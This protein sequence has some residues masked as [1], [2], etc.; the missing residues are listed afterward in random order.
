MAATTLNNVVTKIK[1]RFDYSIQ[2]PTGI[3][4]IVIDA[5]NDSLKT[6]KQLFIDHSLDNEISSGGLFTVIPGQQYRDLTNAVIVGDKTTFTGTAGDTI[7]VTIDGTAY[8][9][10]DI[11]GDT[12]IDDVRDAINTAVG[13]TV[14]YTNATSSTLEIRSLTTGSTS[15]VTIA[16]GTTTAQTVIAELFSVAANRSMTA[17][18][19]LDQTMSA[20]VKSGGDY[21][22]QFI[23]PKEYFEAYPDETMSTSTYG[24]HWML[25][26]DRI[27]IGPTPAAGTI[28]YLE[29]YKLLTDLA[30]GDTMPFENK[31][32][33]LVVAMALRELWQWLDPQNATAA[34]VAHARVEDLTNRLVVNAAKNI[35][36][37]RQVVSRRA[38]GIPYFNPRKVIS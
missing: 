29:Y 9:D 1:R 25:W 30:A 14:A 26:R 13:S 4:L 22:L 21:M 2:D 38:Q 31:Y 7:N 27:Y 19:D 32:D 20:R 16:D 8:A 37:N 12:D 5:V 23:T 18:S 33:P 10:I 15:A 34:Q 3:D 24:D 36:Q 17:I 11:S 35:G 6:I 28:Y